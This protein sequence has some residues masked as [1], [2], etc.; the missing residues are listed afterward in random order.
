[1]KR[2]ILCAMLVAF[3]AIPLNSVFAAKPASPPGLDRAMEAFQKEI[4]RLT[5][6]HTELVARLDMLIQDALLAGD[7]RAA[8]RLGEALARENDQFDRQIAD[9][10]AKLEKFQAKIDAWILKHG[11]PGT[12]EPPPPP[13]SPPQPQ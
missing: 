3:L 1:M 5:Q 8:A 13:P 4:A 12:E 7:L 2:L 10:N 9:L 6:R 11:D